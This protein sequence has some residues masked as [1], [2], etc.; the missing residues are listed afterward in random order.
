MKVLGTI[1]SFLPHLPATLGSGLSA[2]RILKSITTTTWDHTKKSPK[3][4]QG[5]ESTGFPQTQRQHSVG[6]K[7]RQCRKPYI[8]QP[9]A[10][11]SQIFLPHSVT[12]V[13]RNPKQNPK[14][15]NLPYA[16]V[17]VPSSWTPLL[18]HSLQRKSK[19]PYLA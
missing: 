8:L 16:E 19:M 6:H 7:V 9:S 15:A 17:Q 5:V 3:C 13:A 11:L 2:L 12:G 14:P 4:F 18:I 1:Q 10:Q